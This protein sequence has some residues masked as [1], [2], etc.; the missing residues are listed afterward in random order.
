MQHGRVDD[1]KPE[2]P[3]AWRG[4]IPRQAVIDACWRRH[5][6][7]RAQWT[8]D[9]A[10]VSAWSAEGLS[11]RLSAFDHLLPELAAGP[12][13]SVLDLGFGAGT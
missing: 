3:G 1:Q 7:D 13:T 12:G 2:A 4:E 9:E 6:E 5:F 8:S 11:A 10:Q